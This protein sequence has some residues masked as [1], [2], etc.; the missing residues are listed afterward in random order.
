MS[1]SANYTIS[2]SNDLFSI[3]FVNVTMALV[4]A[5]TPTERYSFTV[6]LNKTVNPS[7][8]ITTDNSQASCLYYNTY[9]EGNLYTQM[10][11]SY[12]ANSP[13]TSASVSSSATS[14]L[15]ATGFQPWPYAAEITQKIGG[16]QN[17]PECYKLFNGDL[18]DRITDGLNAKPSEDTCS[19]LWKN[20]DP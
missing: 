3:D 17:V 7:T 8:S 4:D 15:N 1:S 12:P 6:P 18:S 9:L 5:D 14:S 11:H 2:A 13:N 19:C 10:T 16:G 20:F